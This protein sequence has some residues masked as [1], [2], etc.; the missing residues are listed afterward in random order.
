M[1][2]GGRSI[3]TRAARY[4]RLRDKSRRMLNPQNGR[5]AYPAASRN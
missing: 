5:G 4:Q 2:G 3:F 1:P